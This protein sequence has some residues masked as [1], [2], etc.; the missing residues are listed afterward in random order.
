MSVNGK[1]KQ[2]GY[3]ESGNFSALARTL[4]PGFVRPII[5]EFL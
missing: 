5:Y 2:L 3:K 1:G 4:E